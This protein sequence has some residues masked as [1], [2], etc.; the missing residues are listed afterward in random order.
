MWTMTIHRGAEEQAQYSSHL[1]IEFLGGVF[2]LANEL[3]VSICQEITIVGV[4]LT[5]RQ[6]VCPRSEFQVKSVFNG[7][8]R[9]VEE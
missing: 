3:F 8:N 1:L 5:H 2:P 6:A 4:R 9:I 7:L